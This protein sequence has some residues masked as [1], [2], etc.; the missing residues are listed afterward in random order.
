M[1]ETAAL[2]FG[3]ASIKYFLYYLL[4]ERSI[5]IALTFILFATLCILQKATTALPILAV[6]SISFL[7]FELKKTTSLKSATLIK[8]LSTGGIIVVIPVAIGLAWVAFTDQVKIENPLGAQLTS[9]ALDKWNWGTFSQRISSEIWTKVIWDRIF[10]TNVG[11]F[12][13]VFLLTS[14]FF[15]RI[16]SRI[17]FI[18]LGTISLGIL[19]LFLF[20]N[21]HLVHDY[22]Q[23]AN[24]IFLAY[25][26]A[27]ALAVVVAP[28]L[29]KPAALLSLAML[30]TSN[31]I[32]LN[33][34]YLWQLENEFT[35]TNKDLAIGKILNR[36]LAA[37]MQFVAFGN[38]WNS[39]FAYISERKSFTVPPWFK[40]YDRAIS[41]P[42]EFLEAGRLGAIVSCTTKNPT[43]AQIFNWA[44]NNGSWKIGEANGCMVAIPEEKI[45]S[46]V[47]VPTQCKGSIDRAEVETRE[48]KSFVVF[49]GWSIPTE[50]SNNRLENVV[51]RITNK[52]MDP[53]YLNTLKIPR[54]DVN[55]HYEMA[56]DIDIG[57]S[58]IIE[59]K[60]APGNYEAEI[61][62][63]DGKNF[64]SCGVR[65]SF[66]IR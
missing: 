62:Q 63:S 16:E 53:L 32:A 52:D 61:V 28:T 58:R 7:I 57:F 50:D 59:E 18:A 20:I 30:V 42:E 47:L 10:S 31:Y 11:A 3:I 6:L 36:E 46:P 24:V 49:S 2:F 4:G 25:G 40:K 1:I 34:N 41:N 26:V 9:A 35:K 17:K 54:P 15:S 19:P 65:K 29:G 64:K 55:R 66:E 21:L 13:G 38:D 56:E 37:G 27:I 8:N 48:G 60:I 22:Y 51:I 5:K 43:A 12:L 14:L 44:N 39:T 23:T 33:G 45:S